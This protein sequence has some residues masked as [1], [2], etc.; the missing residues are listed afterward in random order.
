[1]G[2]SV[3]VARLPTYIVTLRSFIHVSLIQKNYQDAERE[4]NLP[5][6]IRVRT[7]EH[8][9]R[10]PKQTMQQVVSTRSDSH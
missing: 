10:D 6:L 1:M 3:L 9:D 8:K 4:S 5:M 2:S 7:V